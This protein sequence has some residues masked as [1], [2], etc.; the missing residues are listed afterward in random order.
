LRGRQNK[1]KVKKYIVRD[2]QRIN[3]PYSKEDK[4]SRITSSFLTRENSNIQVPSTLGTVSVPLQ[5]ISFL[6]MT[7]INTDTSLLQLN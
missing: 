2:S 1:E 3:K 6:T 5:N 4:G 7:L